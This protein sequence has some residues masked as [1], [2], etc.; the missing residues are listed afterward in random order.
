MA[1]PLRIEFAGALYHITSRGDGREDIYLNDSDRERFIA[2][3]AQVCERFNWVCHSY[4]LMSNHYHLL[5]E[6]PNGHLSQGMRQLNG[7]YTQAFNRNH[8]RVGHVFQGRYKAILVQKDAYLLELSRYIVLN[9]VRAGMVRSAK[10]WPWS[11]YRCTAGMVESPPWLQ[12]D[13]LLSG[14]SK[15]KRQAIEQY[16]A[17]VAEGKGQPS[18][19]KQLKNQIYLGDDA[20]V[21]EMQC[22]MAEDVNLE[23]VPSIQ[24]RQVAKPLSSYESASQQ[25]NE[26]IYLAYRSGG[27]SMRAI[28]DYFGLHYSSVS[29]IIKSFDDSR[30]KT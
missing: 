7:V 1:R 20:F 22:K 24:K 26:A 4:C 3:L 9:P 12:V 27:Y 10:D 13:W 5:I 6:T 11:S 29:K 18:P 2:V 23:E 21:D 30:F 25:R 17:F 14:F 16:R 15:R 19:W 28:A 8:G